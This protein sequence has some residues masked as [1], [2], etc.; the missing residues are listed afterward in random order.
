LQLP[1][2]GERLQPVDLDFDIDSYIFSA[3]LSDLCGFKENG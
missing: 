2:Y 3:P 1:D